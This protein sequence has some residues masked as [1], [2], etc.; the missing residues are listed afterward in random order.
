MRLFSNYFVDLLLLFKC[1]DDLSR[2][3]LLTTYEILICGYLVDKFSSGMILSEL[4]K[5]GYNK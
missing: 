5:I 4:C 1:H 2:P 3:T